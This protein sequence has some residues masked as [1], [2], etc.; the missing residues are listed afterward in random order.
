MA[1]GANVSVVLFRLTPV[2]GTVTVTAQVAVLLPSAV[3][4][5]IV[6]VPDA[7]AVTF[8]AVE[9]VA[10]LVLLLLQVT[11]L[12]VALLGETVAVSVSV[13][14]GANVSVVL[15]RLTPVTGTV[16]VTAQVAVLLPSA[17]VTVIVAVPDATAVTFPA[18]ETVATLV[19]LLLQVTFLFVALLG[20]IVAVSVSVA[21]GANVSV[22]LFRLTPVTGMFTVTAQVA[23]LPPA[24]AVIVAEPEPLEVTSP[25]DDTVATLLSEDDQATL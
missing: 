6:A 14:F 8:P 10:T 17:V 18:V 25:E 23:D 9:T 16:T 19:L 24:V 20:E 5:V 7:T 12:F 3:V 22:V 21:F 2:T 1:F 15:F 13:A 11:F 4:T